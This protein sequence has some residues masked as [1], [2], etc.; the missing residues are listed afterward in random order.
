MQANDSREVGD[1]E[2][3]RDGWADFLY[4]NDFYLVAIL[5]ILALLALIIAL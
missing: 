4:D 5:L 1:P 3:G 2:Q